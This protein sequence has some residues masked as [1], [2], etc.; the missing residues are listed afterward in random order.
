M[1]RTPTPAGGIP[2]RAFLATGIG[3]GLAVWVLS[4][5]LTDLAEPWDSAGPWWTV[6]WLLVA[7]AGG[8]AGRL[9]GAAL[10]LGYALGQMLATLPAAG[11]GFGLLGWLYIGAFALAACLVSLAVAGTVALLRRWRGR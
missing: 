3:L 4:P 8:A 11:G 9:R 2:T 6:S 7:L 1:A 10:P 5:W